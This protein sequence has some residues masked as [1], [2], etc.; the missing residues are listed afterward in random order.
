[1]KAKA[2]CSQTILLEDKAGRMSWGQI[3]KT[4]KLHRNLHFLLVVL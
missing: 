3:I 4:F 2:V 1:M